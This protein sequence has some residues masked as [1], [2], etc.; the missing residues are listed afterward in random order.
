METYNMDPSFDLPAPL[1]LYKLKVLQ[2]CCSL[3]GWPVFLAARLSMH[4]LMT[5]E[6][7]YLLDL[8]LGVL[9]LKTESG[10]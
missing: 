8:S 4:G 3:P 7:R 5:S 2:G 1:R 10:L 6:G 9:V